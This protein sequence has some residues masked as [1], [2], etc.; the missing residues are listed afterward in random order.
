VNPV[1]IQAFDIST[2]QGAQPVGSRV[3]FRNG[4]PVKGLYRHYAI[5]T[6]EGQDDFAM[7]REVVGR[8]WAHVEAGEEER[9]DLVLI[10]GGAGQVASAIQGMRDAGAGAAGAGAAGLPP[11]VGIAKRLDELYL[12]G[13]QD[14][15]QIPH[16]SSALRLLQ[17]VRDEAHR[18]AITYHRKLRTREGTRS[19]LESAEGIGPALARRLLTR[20]GS[21]QA[22]RAAALADLAAVKGMN[23]RKAE[24]V[25]AAMAGETDRIQSGAGDE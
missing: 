14:P 18:F 4:R 8:S 19:L 7:M 12:P 2:T 6:V 17:R 23:A 24:A 20:F 5:R 21:L 16:T 1:A 11:V 3:F 15:V 13:R 22:L 25:M 9:P 10:D